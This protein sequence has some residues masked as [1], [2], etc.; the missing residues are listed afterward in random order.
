MLLQPNQSVLRIPS[1]AKS[2]VARILSTTSFQMLSVAIAWQ[3]YSLT[4]D[5]FSLGLVGLAQFLPMM[6]LTLI[7][8][9]VADRFDR[10]KIVYIC[11][12]CEGIVAAL[13]VIGNHADWLGREQILLAAAVIGACRA[14][15]GPTLAALVPELVPKEM[16]PQAS[17]WSASAGQTAQ[18][19]GPSLGGLL[20]SLGPAYVYVTAT[21]ALLSAAFLIFWIRM[22]RS[23]RKPEAL[24]LRSVF[25]GLVFVFRHKIILGTT[26]LDLFAVLL[27]GATAL[28]PIF[29]QD[30][31]QTG[32]WGLGLLRSA[33]AV[34]ALLMSLV[35]AHFPLRR[36]LGPTLFGAL[37]IFGLATILFAID[38]LVSIS[39]R[40]VPHRSFGCDQRRD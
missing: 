15:E 10:R 27:G 16:L 1:Y 13:L 9:H 2:W 29:A 22:E 5:A 28:L 14:F 23:V 6:L 3:M 33:P 12:I 30:I 31:L 25:S 7:V 37:G 17:A 8:G 36:A 40:F 32:P 26:S 38:K 24:A 11:Q 39:I 18:I 35:L 20:F 4:G 19:L 34:G 21:V